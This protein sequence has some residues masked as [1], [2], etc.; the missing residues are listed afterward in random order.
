MTWTSLPTPS[1]RPSFSSPSRPERSR[2]LASMTSC[3]QSRRTTQATGPP[4]AA[5]SEFRSPARTPSTTRPARPGQL[6][7]PSAKMALTMSARRRPATFR[8]RRSASCRPMLLSSGEQ[9]A[10]SPVAVRARSP[11]ETWQRRGKARCSPKPSE[12]LPLP[13]PPRRTHRKGCASTPA[14][15]GPSASSAPAGCRLLERERER[16]RASRG[17]ERRRAERLLH[18]RHSPP[19]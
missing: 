18:M 10:P 13:G 8:R 1:A 12:V 15:S 5:P 7:R 9:R 19:S 4:Q 16:S 11:H 2:S 14:S 17:G 6:R 3:G